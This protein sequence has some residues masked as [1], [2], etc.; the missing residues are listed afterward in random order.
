MKKIKCCFVF[1]LCATVLFSC[2]DTEEYIVVN[3]DNSGSYTMKM[4]MGKM[5]EMMQQFGG[6]KTASRQPMP[7]VDTLVYFKDMTAE[8]LTAEEKELYKEGYFKIKVDSATNDFKVEVGCPFKNIAQLPEIRKNL[9]DVSK[10]LGVDK[11]AGNK[12]KET[13]SADESSLL[14][15]EDFSSTLN[16]TAK[17][18]TFTA[19][20][21]KIAYKNMKS[22]GTGSTTVVGDSMMQMMQQLTMLTGEM[23]VKTVITLPAPAKKTGNPKAVLS[24]DKKTI[25][26]SYSLTDLMEKPE[27]GE[28]EIEY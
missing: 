22:S 25:T 24:V 15:S 12:E 10:R 8:K 17:D 21:G 19:V 23:T 4:D 1:L 3:A 14:P 26:L 2:I 27:E 28:Y 6:E 13:A 16:P 11:I 20:P 9:F 7:K 18:F 5:L